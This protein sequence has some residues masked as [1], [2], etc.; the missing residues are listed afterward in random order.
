[1]ISKRG[2]DWLKELEGGFQPDVFYVYDV[3]HI[4]YSFNLEA[5]PHLPV[6]MSQ[7][8]ADNYFRELTTAMG[9]KIVKSINRQLTQCELDALISVAYNVG[10]VP[11][12]LIQAINDGGDYSSA[13]LNTAVTVGGEPNIQ[14]KARRR[15][16]IQYIE[17]CHRQSFFL[18]TLL[19]GLLLLTLK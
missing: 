3:P 4:G 11:S 12:G 15:K 5:H 13:F 16:E 14:L 18:A 1:M 10:H 9:K 8:F 7:Q 6:P 19:T 2:A 17:S